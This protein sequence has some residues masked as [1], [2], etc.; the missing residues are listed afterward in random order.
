MY[1]KVQHSLAP[2]SLSTAS[3]LSSDSA[4]PIFRTSS[5][6]KI[7]TINS[8]STRLIDSR[9]ANC[10]IQETH[11][12]YTLLFRDSIVLN[13]SFQMRQVFPYFQYLFQL[14]SVLDDKNISFAALRAIMARFCGIGRVNTGS[15]ASATILSSVAS[16][17][18]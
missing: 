6:C 18:T 1:T 4:F 2:I 11:T 10:N 13:D 12:I 15:E 8:N 16:P 5:H 17:L 3:S 7:S 9:I 14:F